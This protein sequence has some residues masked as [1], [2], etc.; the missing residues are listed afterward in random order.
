MAVLSRFEFDPDLVRTFQQFRWSQMPGA[1]RPQANGQDPYYDAA[2]WSRLRLSS[3]SFWDV[4]LATPKGVLHVLASHPTPPAFDGPEDRNGARN[5]DEIRLLQSYIENASF[6]MDDRG[7]AGGLAEGESFVI[8]GDLNSDP[9]DGGSLTAGINSLL[10]H[11]RVAHYPAPRSSGAV[12]ASNVQGR[13]NK[14]HRGEAAH[15]TGDFSDRS[16]GNLRVDYVLPSS[17]F[18]VVDSGVFWP[19]FEMCPRKP[20]RCCRLRH[21]IGSPSCL[22]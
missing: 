17:D 1:I 9:V 7:A 18:E 4:P 12:Q 8:V 21:G 5:H 6:L 2:T 14:Q 3:K 15:D 20:E 19:D 11:P 13:A 16:V 10:K 22:G